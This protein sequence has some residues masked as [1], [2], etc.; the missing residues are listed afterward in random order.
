MHQPIGPATTSTFYSACS[1]GFFFLAE[2]SSNQKNEKVFL[3][4]KHEKILLVSGLRGKSKKN[5]YCTKMQKSTVFL[6]RPRSNSDTFFA[7]ILFFGEAE[8][9]GSM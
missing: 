5:L 8:I 7:K 9:I 3:V 2:K 4:Y 1:I 6:T